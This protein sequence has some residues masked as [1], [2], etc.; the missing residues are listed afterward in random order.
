MNPHMRNSP[1]LFALLGALVVGCAS[2]PAVWREVT[3]PHF[4]LRTDLD[5][6]TAR[7]SAAALELNRDMLVSAAWPNINM[8]EWTRAEVYVLAD[9]TEYHV[10]FG[11]RVDSASISGVPQQFFLHGAPE[12]WE[13]RS[14]SDAAP[15]SQLRYHLA[16]RMASLI[17]PTAP[18]WFQV[19][20]AQF[21]E[22]VHLSDDGKSVVLGAINADALRNYDSNRTKSLADLLAW[23]REAAQDREDWR[24]GGLSWLLV[25]WLSNT[26]PQ[27]FSR[28]RAELMQGAPAKSAFATAFP[29]FDVAAAE[30]VLHEY[31]QHPGHTEVLVP[32]RSTPPPLEDR[33]LAPADLHVLQA[34]LAFAYWTFGP[35]TLTEAQLK[36]QEREQIGMALALDS[37]NVEALSIDTWSPV[38][39]RLS[40]AR[41]SAAAHPDDARAWVLLGNLLTEAQPGSPEQEKAFRQ[42][43]SLA[44]K[45]PETLN[46]LAW[47]LLNQGKVAEALPFSMRAMKAAPQ[48]SHILDTYAALMFR[49]GNCDTATTTQQRAVERL[50]AAASKDRPS[51]EKTLAEYQA[52]CAKRRPRR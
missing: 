8:P 20:V 39:H 3:T 37:T 34:R 51:Y 26:Q 16:A 42:A 23:D 10:R 24:L 30:H 7:R 11:N 2:S 4:V 18:A 27:A 9:S 14:M 5:S 49:L 45:N 19:G 29:G 48:Y 17:Y 52:A 22:P 50:P 46:N 31:S 12:H 43:V 15:S 25:H 38:A 28:Y 13:P 41:A 32:L 47:L 6:E 44:P 36:E 1:P 40:R 33:V 35:R 21:L